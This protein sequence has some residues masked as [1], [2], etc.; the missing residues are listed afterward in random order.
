[1]KEYII[2]VKLL[3]IIFLQKKFFLFQVLANR[4]RFDELFEYYDRYT[5]FILIFKVFFFC[6]Q[7]FKFY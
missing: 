5:F 6:F 2:E 4:G 1:M 7:F 3:N